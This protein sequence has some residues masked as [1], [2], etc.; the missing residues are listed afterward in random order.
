MAVDKQGR[1][2]HLQLVD[3]RSEDTIWSFWTVL[4]IKCPG[5]ELIVSDG[6]PGYE[7]ACKK[8]RRRVIHVQHIHKG[9][10]K[11]VKVTLH[12]YDSE[13]RIH[14][15]YQVGMKNGD[16][17]G[18]ETKEIRYLEKS[19]KDS[20]V[21]RPRGRPVGRKDSKSRKKKADPENTGNSSQVEDKKPAKKRGPKNVFADGHRYAID[22]FP[23]Q[24]G[25]GITP[26]DPYTVTLI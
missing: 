26:L 16:L 18:E 9:D 13:K 10:R 8:M 7:K 17:L 11:K 5:I 22:P 2:I 6:L 15:A 25:F 12:G 3:N 19:S 21:K 4:M 14:H 24:Q 20:E 23:D 1:I